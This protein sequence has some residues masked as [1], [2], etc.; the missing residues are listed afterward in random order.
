[1]KQ[2]KTISQG[3]TYGGL[4]LEQRKQQRCQQFLVAGL[5]IFGTQ[6]FRT[7]T[8]RGLCREAKL[9]DRYFY[10]AYGTMEKLLM[11]V[12]EDC[13]TKIRN[14][15]LQEVV[16]VAPG[17]DLNKLIHA[18]L[19]CYFSEMEDA[20]VARVCMLELAGISAEVDE[21]Y[22]GY[23]LGFSELVMSLAQ[24]VYPDWVL[25]SDEMEV[26]GISTIGAMR[27]AATNWLLSDYRVD[28]QILVNSTAKIFIGLMILIESEQ[29]S[30]MSSAFQ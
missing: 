26:L 11:A 24:R 7:A 2:D 12:Y 23:I 1:M 25:S 28:R 17:A 29:N 6:G 3:R 4:S 16:E 15:I 10:E 30:S 14:K 20:R 9:T 21:L 27:Q 19:N 22:N 13:M 8:V 18:A 5:E